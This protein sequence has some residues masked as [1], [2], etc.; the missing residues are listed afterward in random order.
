MAWVQKLCGMFQKA[1]EESVLMLNN[2]HNQAL[3]FAESDG[4]ER[5]RG[6]TRERIRKKSAKLP[7]NLQLF[8]LR[9]EFSLLST[10]QHGQILVD[11]LVSQGNLIEFIPS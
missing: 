6:R 1:S 9:Y 2:K 4:N 11:P 10:H 7:L 5:V 3:V 8:S